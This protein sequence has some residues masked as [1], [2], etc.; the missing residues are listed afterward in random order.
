MPTDPTWLPGLSYDELELRKVDCMIVMGDGFNA[1]GAR[2]GVRPGDPGL[3]VTLSGSTIN[4]SQG[5]AGIFRAGQALYRAHLSTTS[6]GSVAAAHATFTRID[7]VYLRVW[8]NS[9]DASGFLKADAVYLPGTASSTPVAPTPGATEIYIPLATITV[10]PSG[11]GAATVSTAVRPYTVAPGGILPVTSTAAPAAGGPGQVMYYQDTGAFW[12]FLADGTTKALLVDSPGGT[13]IG[14][15]QTVYKTADTPLANTTAL[16]ADPHLTLPVVANAKYLLD[17]YLDYDG[18]F[19][20]TL[21]GLALDWNLPSGATLRWGPLGNAFGDTTQKYTANTTTAGAPLSLGTYGTGGTHTAA[22]PRGY[23]T[24]GANAGSLTL[25]W[26][27]AGATA[28]GTTLYTG[29]HIRLQR[30]A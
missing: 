20:T 4:V 21:G 19:S 28:T 23:L 22:S 24:T 3:T 11:G 15:F 26:A 7:L 6:P 27:Q 17:G 14:K 18:L 25:K 13:P 8:D 1:R 10:P 30:I 16:T 29:S 2:S 5:V 9:F 12:Y